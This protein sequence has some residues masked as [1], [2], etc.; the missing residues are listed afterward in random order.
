MVPEWWSQQW[1]PGD[2]LYSGGLTAVNVFGNYK[3]IDDLTTQRNCASI[4][5]IMNYYVTKY[6]RRQSEKRQLLYQGHKGYLHFAPAK[7]ERR[8]LAHGY[9]LRWHTPVAT[10][11][12]MDIL[13][14]TAWISN[15]MYGAVWDEINHPFPNVNGATVEV[16]EWINYFTLFFITDVITYPC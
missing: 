9:T 6:F 11:T 8:D 7:K 5:T 16:W 3:P 14:I 10:F 2:M 4:G 12:N 15:H 1:T 13:K